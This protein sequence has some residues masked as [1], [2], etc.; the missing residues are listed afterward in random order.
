MDGKTQSTLFDEYVYHE[1]LVHPA[2]TSSPSFLP[3][4]VFVGKCLVLKVVGL[5][6]GRLRWLERGWSGVCHREGSAAVF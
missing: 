2:M 3:K 4:K 6:D 1:A 5:W